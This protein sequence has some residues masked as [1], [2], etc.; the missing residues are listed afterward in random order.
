MTEM[1]QSASQGSQLTILYSHWEN[2]IQKGCDRSPHQVHSFGYWEA[3]T[4]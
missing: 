2:S 4:R 3:T 1:Q